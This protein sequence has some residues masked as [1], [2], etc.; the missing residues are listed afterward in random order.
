MRVGTW[1]FYQGVKNEWRWYHMAADGPVI[2]ASDRGF[3]KLDACMGQCGGGRVW[4][5]WQ[6]SGLPADCVTTRR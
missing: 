1:R 5:E 3:E 2:A 6:L 4:K